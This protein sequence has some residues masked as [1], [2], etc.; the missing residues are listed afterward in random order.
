MRFF[1][2]L[3]VVFHHGEQIRLTY[4]F[5][6]F[7]DLSIFKNGGLAV[8]FFFVLSGFLITYR[9]LTQIKSQ[10]RFAIKEFYIKRVLRIWPVYFLLV[11]LGLVILPLGVSFLG[12]NYEMPYDPIE[13]L[14]YFIFFSPFLVNVFYSSHLLEPLWSI[15]VEEIFYLFWAPI[16][17]FNFKKIGCIISLLFLLKICLNIWSYLNLNQNWLA[18]TI[19]LL[20]FEAMFIGGLGAVYLLNRKKTISS[21]MS[22]SKPIQ[23]LVFFFLVLRV[24]FSE[25]LVENYTF[26]AFLFGTPVVSRLILICVFAWLIINVSIN[27]KSLIKLR[28]NKLE[29]LGDI[30]YGIYMYHMLVLFAIVFLG[31]RLVDIENEYLQFTTFYLLAIPIIIIVSSISKKY[32]EDYFLKKK[33]KLKL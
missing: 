7:K 17:K 24:L 15:G 32:F 11:F 9:S 16:L 13:V 2:A 25:F 26:G 5:S 28:S 6:N 8:T 33:K 14:P 23:V 10:K 19:A 20:Q 1:A 12:L 29:Y 22:F 4:G 30:S 31:N 21:S 3:F 18:Q 27:E